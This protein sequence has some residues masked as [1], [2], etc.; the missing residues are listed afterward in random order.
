MATDFNS[1]SDQFAAVL[2]Q[3]SVLIDVPFLK[4][5]NIAGLTGALKNL[6]HGLVKHP[7]RYHGNKCSPYIGDIVAAEPVRT[8]L[9]LCLVD[10]LRVVYEGGPAAT[11]AT[12]SD[13]GILL[14]SIDPVATDT[15]GLMVLNEVRE[16]EGLPR[17][18]R[19]GEEVDYIAAAHRRGLGVGI[20]HG[21]DW[22]RL[23]R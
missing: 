13:E 2:K 3:I 20:V 10:A 17:I 23:E 12:I 7:A 19:S 18:A 16:R 11:T 14:A 21:I 5:H 22:V 15:I 4:T 9:R 6:S 1:G 8:R